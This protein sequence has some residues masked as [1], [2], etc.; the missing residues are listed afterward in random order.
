MNTLPLLSLDDAIARWGEY[1]DL[2]EQV[3][4]EA[5]LQS[6]TL[7]YAEQAVIAGKMRVFYDG[8]TLLTCAL[9]GDVCHII[10]GTGELEILKATLPAIEECAK[11]AGATKMRITGR[12]GWARVLTGYTI[13]TTVLEKRL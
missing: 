5:P 11:L 3:I 6:M 4:A 1:Q 8:N 13:V 10:H 2:L 9:V 12:T 7:E